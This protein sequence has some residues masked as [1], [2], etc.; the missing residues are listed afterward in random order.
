M[1]TFLN[2]FIL[3]V[4]MVG[5]LS[6]VPQKKLAEPETVI[7]KLDDD[8]GLREGSLVYSLPMTVFTIKIEME[9]TIDV[10]GPY[11]RFAG[12][13]LGLNKVILTEAE[14]WTI[15]G[16]SLNLHEEADPSECYVIE[17][18]T[19]FNTN[20]LTLK[21]E[22]LIL[23][24]NPALY[25]SELSLSG[26]NNKESDINNF[27]SYDL[28]SDEYFHVQRDT[29]YKRVNVDSTFIRIPYLVEKKKR[30]TIDQLA[31]NAAKRLIELREGK[32]LILTGEANVF[33]QNAAALNEIN[34]IER[35]YTEL[36][37]GKSWKENKTLSF[38]L[39]PKKDMIGK[40]VVLFRYS[41][42]TGPITGTEN[43]GIPVAVELVPEK[44]T[45]DITIIDRQQPDKAVQK[46]DKLFF[47]VPDVVNVKIN[48]GTETLYNSRRLIYQFGQVMQLPANYIIGK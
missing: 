17:T 36:F 13:L 19:L 22:G 35:E 27:R 1:R 41:E 24:L 8:S 16:I 47:R 11:S 15:K 12:D 32:V 39:V 40:P 29:A 44:K 42:Q 6:C 10:P 28:G 4:V 14:N 3:S 21:K 46:Y 48:S 5:M 34:R 33:P 23:D 2:L 38:H 30:L 45:R 37:A 7:S 25:T 26:N 18:N 43:I 31:E 9:R 20:A